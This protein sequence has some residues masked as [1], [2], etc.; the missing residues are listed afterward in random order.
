MQCRMAIG[1]LV[2]AL[3][4]SAAA[5]TKPP[6]KEGYIY[7]GVF[8]LWAARPHGRQPS[9]AGLPITTSSAQCQCSSRHSRFRLLV[10]ACMHFGLSPSPLQARCKWWL[11]T[12]AAT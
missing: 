6:E 8:G 4:V 1:A 10:L 12:A 5:A 2:L 7:G 3:G 9:A 11:S